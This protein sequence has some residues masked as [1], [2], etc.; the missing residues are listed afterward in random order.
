MTMDAL[1]DP[2]A[3]GSSHPLSPLLAPRSIALL[4]ASP[5]QGSVGNA[6]ARALLDSGFPGDIAFINPRHRQVEGQDCHGGLS[7]LA[8][9][10]DLAI[11]NV[12][13]A[14]LE[15]ALTD[16][17]SAGAGAAVI[18]DACH[19]SDEAG[20]PIL[21]RLRDI[22][23][24]AAFPVCGGN[25][26]GFFDVP[27]RC[28]ASFYSA[29]HLQPGGI[30]L[31]AHSGSV[32][33]VLA[34]NDPRYRFDLLVSPGQEI[35]ATIDRYLDY[36]LTRPTTRVIALFMEAARDPQGFV[37]ALEKARQKG[38]PV[39]VC[40]V[41]RTQESARLAMSHSGALA[42]SDLAYDVVLERYGA[43]RV[44]T[45]DQLMNVSLL[46]SQDRRW[47][48]GEAGLVTDSGG[49]R[50]LLIDRAQSRALPL[51]KLSKATKD[52]LREI[53]PP[54]LPPSNPLDCAGS[55]A[56]DFDAVF[57]K[58]LRILG[59]APEVGILGYEFDARDDFT[60][61]P[62]LM[63]LAGRLP[64]LTDK[65]FFA[66]S[67]F[68]QAN[69]LKTAED[70]AAR[71]VPL[72]NGLDET[73]G[74]LAALRAW[75]DQRAHMSHD[76]PPPAPPDGEV[77]EKWRAILGSGGW[78][79]EAQGL[80][81]L[82]DFGIP[83]VAFAAC[84]DWAAV[85][86]AAKQLGFPLVL[87]TAEK[88]IGHK[89]DVGGVK[90]NLQAPD[91][92]EAAYRDLAGRLGPDV[93]LQ[94]M[95][96]GGTELAFGYLRDPDFGP[97]VMVS[98]GGTLIEVLADRQFALAPFGPRQA[99]RMLGRLKLFALLEG[100]RG[101]PTGDIDSLCDALARFSVLC[102][103]LSDVMTEADVNPIFVGEAGVTAVDAL[104]GAG[105]Q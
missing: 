95:A 47:E 84:A 41:G 56:E 96:S 104:I 65:P 53:L 79:G 82:G 76:D 42:G 61:H 66:Y 13:A 99:R 54:I 52:D 1:A 6:T 55:I 35:G 60:Y 101:G 91:Q 14:R 30:T 15:A 59:A 21:Q 98:A 33:T 23:R 11:L 7:E 8:A 37:Q 27:G 69:N 74:A 29:S 63:D 70:L 25:G 32:F 86:A 81:M 71:G 44:E 51:A 68:A 38:V 80:A 18:F 9:P 26:M 64:Q 83:A 48:E 2:M 93:L 34:L 78:I 90:A 24:E 22:A 73:L 28:H 49:L 87:K 36:A 75:R 77:V 67:S 40:K 85:S 97:I 57:E 58:G 89:T 103:A 92:L 72:I 45:V 62:G 20:R 43:I 5:R 88:D 39:V 46:L 12:G 31:V 105:R 50:E 100:V 102:A 94:A 10:P 17:I 3:A 16:T 19:G 4:G